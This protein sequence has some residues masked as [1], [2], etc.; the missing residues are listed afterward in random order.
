MG[1][2]Q[3]AVICF[4]QVESQPAAGWRTGSRG[5][6]MALRKAVGACCGCLGS[7]GHRGEMQKDLDSPVVEL[8][9]LSAGLN[10]WSF[11]LGATVELCVLGCESSSPL[12]LTLVGC[13]SCHLP[14]MR[15]VQQCFV[16]GSFLSPVMGLAQSG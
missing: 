15:T 8:T 12:G 1:Y 10:Y 13:V 3:S 2:E 11:L 5:V 4:V 9:Q 6:R 14:W 7:L 16:P